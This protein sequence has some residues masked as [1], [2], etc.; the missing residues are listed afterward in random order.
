MLSGYQIPPNTGGR[1]NVFVAQAIVTAPVIWTTAAGTG[2]PLLYNGSVSGTGRGV[3][4][5]LLALSY[6][7]T[8]AATVAGAVGLT[9]G[10][11]TAPTTTTAIDSSACLR[12]NAGSPTPLCSV[13]RVGT[14]SAAGTFFLPTGQVGTSALTAEIA[15]DNFISLG[16]VVEVGPGYFASFAASATLS[17]AVLQVGLVWLEVPND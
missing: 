14:V 3:T 5:Y 4:A 11:T 10:P 13:Y 1:G 9:G 15:D 2:G 7:L 16:G 17:T 6:G 12:L 8:T